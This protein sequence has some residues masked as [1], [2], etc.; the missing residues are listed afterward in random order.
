M[1]ASGQ[2]NAP[3][4]RRRQGI[5]LALMEATQ[6]FGGPTCSQGHYS[7]R[8]QL[9]T[10]GS[11]YSMLSSYKRVGRSNPAHHNRSSIKWSQSLCMV[12]RTIRSLS[13]V[14]EVQPQQVTHIAKNS[15]TQ[16]QRT[17]QMLFIVDF[18]LSARRHRLPQ[19]QGPIYCVAGIMS[20]EFHV[21]RATPPPQAP[22]PLLGP[23]TRTSHKRSV[24]PHH[25][26]RLDRRRSGD[27]IPSDAPLEARAPTP[28]RSPAPWQRIESA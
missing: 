13:G 22:R 9:P 3:P 11:P 4:V 18:S 28:W 12:P 23:G 2:K 25:P 16:R 27:K 15:T 7:I 24:A 21:F 5:W 10:P 8:A 20:T 6:S 19:L 26:F 14:N 1:P 17:I